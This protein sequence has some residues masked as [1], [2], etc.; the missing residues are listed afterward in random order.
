M[1][2]LGHREYTTN[3]E[4]DYTRYGWGRQLRWAAPTRRRGPGP[5]R[6]ANAPGNTCRANHTCRALC[7]GAVCAA[8]TP[9]NAMRIACLSQ[10]WPANAG[11]TYI[12][13]ATQRLVGGGAML[14]S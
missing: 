2:I 7:P 3:G 9:A 8:H 10:P 6:L 5:A 4:R 1:A 12:L 13:A 11:C 14:G